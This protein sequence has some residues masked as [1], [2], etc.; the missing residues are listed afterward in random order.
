AAEVV[1]LFIDA[2]EPILKWG[3][4]SAAIKANPAANKL[5]LAVL[6]NRQTAGAPEALAGALSNAERALLV[7]NRSAGQA[8]SFADFPLSNGQHLRIAKSRVELA[9]GKAI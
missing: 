9:N 5:P 4:E 2:A 8:I 6:I 7:G 3:D 1:N